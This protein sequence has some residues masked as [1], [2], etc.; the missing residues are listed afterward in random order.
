[1]KA[2]GWFKRN[3]GAVQEIPCKPINVSCGPLPGTPGEAPY[4]QLWIDARDGRCLVID[5]TPEEFE[6]FARDVERINRWLH[7]PTDTPGEP[8][9][10]R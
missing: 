5:M 1:M 8:G 3:L 10:W 2:R 6:K 7:A 9:K 4:G